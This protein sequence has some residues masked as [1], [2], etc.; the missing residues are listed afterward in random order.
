M[1]PQRLWNSASTDDLK[2]APDWI[3]RS[4]GASLIVMGKG[5]KLMRLSPQTVHPSWDPSSAH[6]E[7]VE[8]CRGQDKWWCRISSIDDTKT[9]EG[10]RGYTVHG[11]RAC[12]QLLYSSEYLSKTTFGIAHVLFVYLSSHRNY[13]WKLH[14]TLTCELVLSKKFKLNLQLCILV[15]LRI[16]I[17]KGLIVTQY[18]DLKNIMV[19]G[20]DVAFQNC[21]L[22]VQNG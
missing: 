19:K 10:L 16:K 17:E 3:A 22:C 8:T 7:L 6:C 20:L 15:F 13:S 14:E 4:D 9:G 1:R 18:S 12:A 21:T 5:L 11:W 2:A